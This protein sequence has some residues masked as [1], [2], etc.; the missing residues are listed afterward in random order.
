MWNLLWPQGL[1][2]A[3]LP[4]GTYRRQNG[5]RLSTALGIVVEK[6]YGW[7]E[8][9]RCFFLFFLFIH[10]RMRPIDH[11]GVYFTE[12]SCPRSSRWRHVAS[13]PFALRPGLSQE[14]KGAHQGNHKGEYQRK[15]DHPLLLACRCHEGGNEQEQRQFLP[16]SQSSRGTRLLRLRLLFFF[17]LPALPEL[18][19]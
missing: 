9:C 2:T 15:S 19:L 7:E 14:D 17:P 16:G 12:F 6:C 5:Q 10:T 1:S 18:P 4:G 8:G 3:S 13:T 11:G